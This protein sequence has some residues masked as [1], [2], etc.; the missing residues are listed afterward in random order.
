MWLFHICGCDT[1]SFTANSSSNTESSQNRSLMSKVTGEFRGLMRLQ[2]QRMMGLKK[3]CPLK[4]SCWLWGQRSRPFLALR[5]VDVSL[6]AMQQHVFKYVGHGGWFIFSKTVT[7]TNAHIISP[8]LAS[9]E[10]LMHPFFQAGLAL[11]LCQG[12]Q[13]CVR[14][15]RCMSGL[16]SVCQG[17]KVWVKTGKYTPGW[18]K[19]VHREHI[20]SMSEGLPAF[21]LGIKYKMFVLQ[22]TVPMFYHEQ[23]SVLVLR[24]SWCRTGSCSVV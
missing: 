10:T 12:G 1:G 19:Y 5:S 21:F 24:A 3:S 18:E 22:D 16:E 17:Q 14:V 2:S 23:S 7:R 15:G 20:T 8:I 9:R 6:V 11:D 13:V 4:T